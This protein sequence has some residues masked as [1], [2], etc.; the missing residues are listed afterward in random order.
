MT[1]S[2]PVRGAG[3][4]EDPFRAVEPEAGER[5]HPGLRIAFVSLSPRPPPFPVR[6][7]KFQVIMVTSGETTFAAFRLG[8]TTGR[9]KGLENGQ[10]FRSNLMS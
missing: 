10:C 3:P 7:L 1:S 9:S 6:V 4:E 8:W 5:P 2:R